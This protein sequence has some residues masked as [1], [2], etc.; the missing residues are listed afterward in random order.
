MC[1]TIST[2]QKQIAT[3][4]KRRHVYKVVE[5]TAPGKFT[6]IYYTGLTYR[7]GKVARLR[8]GGATSVRDFRSNRRSSLQGV[9]V[10]P[11]LRLSRKRAAGYYTILKCEVDPVDF[12]YISVQARDGW[13][14]PTEVTYRAIKPV[15]VVS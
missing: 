1:F 9:Y 14:P 2:D 7:L 8:K 13:G 12:L 15:K 11:N 6:G 5:E 3:A 10:Y 4:K